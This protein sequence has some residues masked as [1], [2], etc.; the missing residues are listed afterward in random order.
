VDGPY[1]TISHSPPGICSCKDTIDFHVTTIKSTQLAFVY[2]C[3]SGFEIINPIVPVGTALNPTSF[4]F[5]VPYCITDS[6]LPQLT[7]GDQTGCQVLLN[8]AYVYVDSPVVDIAFNNY[9]ICLSGTVN[10]FEATHYTLPPSIS[11]SVDWYWDFG[12]PFDTAT[13]VQQNPTHYYSQ[14]GLFPV[15]LKVH[16]NFGCY[17]SIISTSVV[18]IP[19]FPIAGFYGDDSLICAES[20]TC[21]HDTSYIDPNTGPQYWYWDFGDG[22]TDSTSGPNPCHTYDT[23][24]YFIVHL[25]IYD[26]IGCGDCDSGFLVRVISLPNANAGPDTVFCIG[27]Q[28]QL[29]GSG[30]LSCH[31]DPIGLVSNPNICNPITTITVDTSFV[32]T[33]TD[34]Y[35]CQGRDTLNVLAGSVNASFAVSPTSCLA[36]SVCVVDSSTSVNGVVTTWQ[37]NFG[38]SAVLNGASVCYQYGAPGNYNIVETVTDNHGC[39]DTAAHSVTILPQPVA[40]FSLNDTVICSNEPVCYTDLSTSITTIQS[41]TWNFGAGQ[42]NFSGANPPC[43]S[44]S[45]VPSTDTIKLEIIDLNGCHDSA[46][47]VLTVNKIPD[48]NFTGPPSCE[49]KLMQLIN[50]SQQGSPTGAIDSCTWVF[51]LGAPVP[52]VSNNCNPFFQFPP[53]D[54]D[55]QLV[56]H[57]L[58]GCVDTIVKSVH[59]DSLSQLTV[60]PGDTTLCLGTTVDYHV[61]GVY[62]NITWTPTVWI[63]DPYASTVTISPLGNIGYIISAVNGVCDAAGDTFAVHVIQPIPI[64]V[65]AT[66]DKIVLGLSSNITSQIPGQID[67]IIWTPDQ[68]LDC[69]NCPNPVAM[70]QATTTYTATIYYSQD[71]ITCTNSAEVTITVL[72][73]CNESIVYLPNTFTPNNDG[74]N[75]VFMI[76][77]IAATKINYFRVFDRWG[78]L[79]FETQNGAA[80]EPRWGWDGTDMQGQKLNPAVFVYTYE[81]ECINHDVVTGKGNVALVR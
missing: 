48:A 35:G 49:D 29:N 44:Y 81:I 54:H 69:N 60:Y 43:R 14:P 66:P 30:S 73:N 59:T 72:N 61:S 62:D 32:L 37:Y 25:C 17:D 57:D 21:F 71:G 68:T 38:G 33:V 19:K 23:G 52:T 9:G 7:F 18:V 65:M 39:L 53:G 75:D 20:S 63:S 58:N 56:V 5:H 55:V 46:M 4:D 42:G 77:G 50:N 36:D 41:W 74:I 34:G 16:S 31:W 76:R 40:A 28:T 3:N 70:P 12:D 51:W 45:P 2:G 15:T 8:D 78:K 1:G 47:I 11:H 22:K 6:C 79:V 24:G 67:S 13:S 26:S 64:E 27:A 10:F 80:N